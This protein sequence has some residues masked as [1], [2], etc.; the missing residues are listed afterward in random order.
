MSRRHRTVRYNDGQHPTLKGPN[1]QHVYKFPVEDADAE[2]SRELT[3]TDLG[4]DVLTLQIG[5]KGITV[6]LTVQDQIDLAEV[7]QK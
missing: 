1:M 7:L 5:S 2:I 6:F 3:V 4:N